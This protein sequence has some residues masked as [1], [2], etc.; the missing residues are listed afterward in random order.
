MPVA[1]PGPEA[2]GL[3]L[4]EDS[5]DLTDSEIE[6]AFVTMS[7]GE[8]V[9][10]LTERRVCRAEGCGLTTQPTSYMLRRRSPHLYTRLHLE[11]DAGHATNLVIRTDWVR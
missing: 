5:S 4:E 6:A 7:G 9:A 11:C 1:P 3:D 8:M 10:V 2:Y